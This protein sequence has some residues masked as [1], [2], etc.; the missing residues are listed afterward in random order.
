MKRR[1]IFFLAIVMIL[2]A[3]VTV[4][5]ATSLRVQFYNG[6]TADISNTIF[7]NIKLDNTG[8][9]AITLSSVKM[10][11]YFTN[12][13]TQ[14]NNFACDWSS[15]GNENITGTFTSITPV[16]NADRYLEIGFGSGAGSLA[17]GASIYAA[18]RI[19]KS[20]WSNFTQT[21]DY[22]FNSS[23]TSHVGWPAIPAYINGV[24]YWGTPPGGS[25]SPSPTVINT[26]TPGIAT[27]TPGLRTPTPT[28]TPTR[29][30]T[31][32]GSNPNFALIG[33]AT[34]NGGTTGG[35]GGPTVTVSTGTDLQKAIKLGGPRII[36]VNGTITPANSSGLSKI[37]IK[38]V[39]NISILGV[40]TS[41]ELNGIGIKIWRASNIIIRN[42]KI[43]HVNIGDKDCI[44][45][46]GPSDHIW[47]DH[48]ELYNDLNHDK[49]YYDGLL[50]A[51]SN[52]E[53]ITFSWNYLHDSYKTSLIGSSDS[54]NYDR[55][56][57]Y[58]HNY[59]GNC[60]SRLPLW[61]FGTG[62]LFNNYWNGIIDTG[63]NSRMGAQLR[64]E[65]NHFENSKDPIG[66][67]YSEATGYWDVRNNRFTNCTGSQPITSTCTFNPP[68]NYSLDAVD[69]VKSMVMQYAGVGKVNP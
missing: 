48:C 29:T 50:D 1:G 53:Y 49:D 57:T 58:H 28:Q 4:S 62:H 65:N 30:P 54:D 60:Y 32:G 15:A 31:P 43:H 2:V 68:Y 26:P 16:T 67:W 66:F 6:N 39:S 7:L 40:G 52:C 18:I 13:G 23:A 8:T 61:R 36:Y 59:F 44:S 12:D 51:K 56:I 41:G 64:I 5:A 22:S 19:W 69:S 9:E 37:D 24:L 17:P 21:N 14:S 10:R 33:F 27:P 63:I 35:Q 34:L 46:E 3:M 42:L 55:K 45:I 25:G 11:Y 20:D 38:D 47:V